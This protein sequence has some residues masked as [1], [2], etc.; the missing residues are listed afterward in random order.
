MKKSKLLALI[1]AGCIAVSSL[2]AC[3]AAS[4]TSAGGSAPASGSASAA[5]GVSHL[6]IMGTEG[7]APCTDWNEVGEYSAFKTLQGWL[8]E[9]KLDVEWEV[10]TAEQYP[11]ILQT[12]L[13]SGNDLPD[14]V[15]V[16]TL[17]D[18]ALLA[19]AEQGLIIPINEIIDKYSAGPAREAFNKTFPSVRPLTTA[20]DGNMYWFC[21]VQNKYYGD[22]N[23]ANGS[24]SIL[25]RRDWADALEIDEPENLEEFTQMLRDFRTKDANGNGQ[26]DEILFIDPSSFRTGIAQWFDLATGTIALDPQQ[27]K[28]VTPWKNPNVKAYFAYL[29]SLV[30]EGILDP[31]VAGN[32][33]LLTQ[34]RAENKIAAMWD[35]TNAMWNE[36]TV[37]AIAPD[38][39]YAPL[40]PLPAVDGVEPASMSEPGQMVWERYA[41]TK[42][43]KD[44]EAVARLLDIVY[45]E[46]YATL[47]AF[48]E[49]GVNFTYDEEG[50]MTSCGLSGDELREQRIAEGAMLWNGVLPRVQSVDMRQQVSTCDD[51]KRDVTLALIDYDKKYPDQLNNFLALPTKEESDRINE[52]QANLDTASQELATK[53]TLGKI[54]LSDLEKEV[55]KLDELGLSEMLEIAQARYDRYLANLPS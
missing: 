32:Y 20:E 30:N 27:N 39:L 7:W 18:A 51:Y 54:P 53:L 50:V 34:K 19:L 3:G 47:T 2:T 15:K 35:Y 42:D 45:S 38:A 36:P 11:V 16:H 12:R 46:D 26:Q 9:A 49:E 14:I 48:G 10:I 25:Y 23:D 43:C 6:K 24:F 5:D 21:N 29:N 37:Q 44:L 17:D 33:E 55:E 52:L 31:A 28:I 1:L 40:M 41:V 4:G 8:D 22:N 13:A